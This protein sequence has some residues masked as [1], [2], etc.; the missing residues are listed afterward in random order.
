VVD[1]E[2]EKTGEDPSLEAEVRDTL[3]SMQALAQQQPAV[4]E[5]EDQS[6]DEEQME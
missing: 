6:D 2:L 3:T 4:A 1:Q 5:Q